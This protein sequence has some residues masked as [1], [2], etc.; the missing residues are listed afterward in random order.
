MQAWTAGILAA[1]GLSV[2]LFGALAADD[3]QAEHARMKQ[4]HARVHEEHDA[5]LRQ[6][7]QWRIEHR[8]ALAALR[9]IEASILE[10][11]ATLEELAEHAREH[12]DHIRHHDEEI[13]EHEKSGDAKH[14]AELAKLH[15]K[16]LD[17]HADVNR[18]I[19][20]F[21][22]DHDALMAGLKKLRD[23]VKKK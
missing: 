23:S 4:E 6:L 3:H 13:A 5:L 2:G 19:H 21:H 22:D 8:R 11:E 12:E 7:S 18:R 10:H 9:E 15:K 14:H 16:L 1:A 17:E 20:E